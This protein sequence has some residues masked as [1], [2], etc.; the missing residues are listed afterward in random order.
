MEG[1][2]PVSNYVY[3]HCRTVVAWQGGRVRLSPEQSWAADDPFVKARPE[4][5]RTDPGRVERTEVVETATRAPGE[6]R[7]TPPRRPAARR[8]QAKKD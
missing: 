5:F 4:L 3:P 2:D 1:F 8:G 7:Q 6:V